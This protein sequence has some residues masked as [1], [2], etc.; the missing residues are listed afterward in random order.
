MENTITYDKPF[1]SY[2]E[3]IEIMKSRN[4]RIDDYEFTKKTLSSLSYY[5][6]INGYKNTFLQKKGSDNFVEGT[7]FTDL[8]TLHI[9]D[10]NINSIL[11]KNI[12]Y[13]ERYLKTRISYIISQNYGVYTDIQDLS[14]TNPSDYLCRDNYSRS[15]P[16]RN[17]ILKSIKKS[18]SS[19]RINEIVAH[20]A[21]TKNHI[22]AWILTTNITFGL[23]IKWYNILTPSDKGYICNEFLPNSSIPEMQKKEYILKSLSLLR[24]YR[25]KIAHGNRTFSVTNLPVLPKSVL[26]T[27]ATDSL[28][29][30]EY[31]SGYGKSD[32]YAVILSC[33]ILIDDK[34]IALNFLHD[35]QYTLRP[36][37]KSM[38]NGKSVF[39]ILDLPSNLFNRIE[40]FISNKYFT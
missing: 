12:L 27:L 3:L 36:Y 24:T 8:Y 15:A 2:D 29:E 10:T 33:L 26:L 23:T 11:L 6:I 20:Y 7:N 17:N 37:E 31:N 16:G 34:Y 22:P 39:E 21:N 40:K 32:L 1:K 13:V 18:L 14:N 35:L 38:M 30:T 9:I 25:N 5:T 4:I 19:D 28:S